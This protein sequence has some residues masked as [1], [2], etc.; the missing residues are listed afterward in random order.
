MGHSFMID[1]GE[2]FVQF[3]SQLLG[4]F[5]VEDLRA[6]SDGSRDSGFP[7]DS[8]RFHA[9]SVDDTIG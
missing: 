9:N 4:R 8:V 7:M 3:L 5:P 1:I 6:G 2:L